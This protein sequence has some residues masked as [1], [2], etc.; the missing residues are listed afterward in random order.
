MSSV[1]VALSLT[2][3]QNQS[4]NTCYR[5]LWTAFLFVNM[6]HLYF[7]IY[8]VKV[9]CEIWNSWT[10]WRSIIVAQWE[11]LLQMKECSSKIAKLGIKV[12]GK[13][14]PK[15]ISQIFYILGDVSNMSDQL[16]VS[17]AEIF[18]NYNTLINSAG[19]EIQNYD[20]L[21]LI[22]F[23]FEDEMYSLRKSD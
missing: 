15:E 12:W 8:R 7:P 1:S 11:I 5:S 13:W 4:L 14:I 21:T 16:H 3:R 18:L 19:L 17:T 2:D 9:E 20:I 10:V 22:Q 6:A 23:L